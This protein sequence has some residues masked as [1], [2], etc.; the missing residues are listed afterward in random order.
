MSS[1]YVTEVL[2]PAQRKYLAETLFAE[3]AHGDAEHR[4]WLKKKLYDYFE[5]AFHG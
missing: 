1:S 5:V 3:M 2:T 4:L